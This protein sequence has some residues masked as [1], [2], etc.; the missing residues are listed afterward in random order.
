MSAETLAG[1]EA[2]I[3]AHIADEGVL[4]DWFVAYGSM[5][6]DPDTADGIAYG[7]GYAT[8]Q[9]SPHGALGIATLGIKNLTDDL[10]Y[11]DEDDE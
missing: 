7:I 11:P 2:A 1:I 8:S 6:H 10:A 9:T 5:S 4:T 3:A